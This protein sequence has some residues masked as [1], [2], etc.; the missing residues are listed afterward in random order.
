MFCSEVILINLIN[1]AGWRLEL[2]ALHSLLRI[3]AQRSV[4]CKQSKQLLRKEVFFFLSFC[5]A[6]F[7]LIHTKWFDHLRQSSEFDQWDWFDRYEARPRG[8][9]GAHF[10]EE[11]VWTMLVSRPATY[12]RLVQEQQKI[13]CELQHCNWKS[14]LDTISFM[15]KLA[16]VDLKSLV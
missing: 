15:I 3:L 12:V 9:R 6:I 7:R 2:L 1:I 16:T 4:K 11:K 5:S 14:Y 10:N 13:M 8:R